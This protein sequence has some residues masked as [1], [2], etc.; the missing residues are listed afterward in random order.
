MSRKT[1]V[2]LF[3]PPGGAVGETTTSLQIGTASLLCLR[4]SWNMEDEV[5]VDIE[6]DDFDSN[7]G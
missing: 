6:G 4:L 1:P 5:D 2:S 7:V 3:Q